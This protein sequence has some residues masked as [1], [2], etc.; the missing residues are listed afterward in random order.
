MGEEKIKVFLVEDN[1]S[2]FVLIKEM[3]TKLKDY[4]LEVEGAAS[5]NESIEKLQNRKVDVVLLDLNLPDS[6][7]E[8][9]FLKLYQR[10]PQ[11]P[12]VV[13]TGFDDEELAVKVVRQGAQDYLVKGRVDAYLTVKAISYAIERKRI[14]EA[15]RKARDELELRVKER[16]AELV[17]VNEYLK[18]EVEE[19]KRK[20]KELRITYIKLKEVQQQ[21]IRSAKM[22]AVGALASGVAHEVKNPLAII[23]QGIEYLSKKIETDD[24]NIKYTLKYMEEAVVRADTIVKGLLDFSRISKLNIGKYNINSLIENCLLLMKHQFDRHHIQVVKELGGNIPEV[25]I[26]KSKIEQVFINIFMNAVHAMP[27]GGKLTIRS[28]VKSLNKDTLP[29]QFEEKEKFNLDEEVVI[30]EI[31]DTGSGIPQELLNKVFDPF[32]TTKRTKG[33]TGLG[34]SIVRSIMDMH[35]GFIDIKNKSSGGVIVTLIFKKEG[36]KYG[37]EKD[38]HSR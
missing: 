34:L 10:F 29:L 16:T 28:Y 25:D 20:E 4:S 36:G 18:Q 3:L 23:L 31:E 6:K 35:N 32:F 27:E 14:E 21:L 7:G 22:E 33:G 24:E 8:D 19:R 2:E 5:L 15:L 37:E 11:L 26:D 1:P 9:T 12:V 13:L 30:V 38:T 17:R